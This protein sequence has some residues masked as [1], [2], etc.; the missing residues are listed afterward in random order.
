M[1]VTAISLGIALAFLMV[2][3]PA[4][5]QENPTEKIKKESNK[6][7]N[8]NIDKLFNRK[9]NKEEPVQEQQEQQEQ[10]Q[11][12]QEKSEEA[13]REKVATPIHECAR[14]SRIFVS[15]AI[16]CELVSA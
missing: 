14:M 11:Q 4:G 10:T 12:Q 2:V 3:Q 13:R 6:V 1:K 16:I 9:K 5:A 15:F 7:I 8:R